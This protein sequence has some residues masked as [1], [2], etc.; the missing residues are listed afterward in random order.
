MA[1]IGKFSGK[2]W[3]LIGKYNWLILLLFIS[4]TIY[5]YSVFKQG[6]RVTF[7]LCCKLTTKYFSTSQQC[8]YFLTFSYVREFSKLKERKDGWNDS[9]NRGRSQSMR[10]DNVANKVDQLQK[11][12]WNL[13]RERL[14]T[15]RCELWCWWNKRE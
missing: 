13:K 11:N 5:S 15:T 12:V 10:L 1:L 7:Y 9:C 8:N 14:R 6:P 3:E 2:R 4:S